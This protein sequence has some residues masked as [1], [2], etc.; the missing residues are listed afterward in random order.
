MDHRQQPCERCPAASD[1]KQNVR[2]PPKR[3]LIV[4]EREGRA[5]VLALAD[6]DV[7]GEAGTTS[8][9]RR[10]QARFAARAEPNSDP[11]ISGE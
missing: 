4:A 10:W 11:F 1:H 7:E 6:L 8:E 2:F 9:R 5:T 3:T